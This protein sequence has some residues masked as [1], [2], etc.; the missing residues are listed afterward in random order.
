MD[1]E[2]DA[3]MMYDFSENVPCSQN[4]KIGYV[5]RN[6]YTPQVIKNSGCFSLG[7]VESIAK[8]PKHRLISLDA[9]R[10]L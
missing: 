3:N 9:T 7:R 1:Y 6:T 10:C 8:W 2:V 4:F 5:I